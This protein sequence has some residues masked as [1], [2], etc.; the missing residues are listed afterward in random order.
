MS[1]RASAYSKSANQTTRDV[2]NLANLSETASTSRVLNLSLIH[3]AS[4]RDPDYSAAP[5]FKN[6]LLNKSLLIKHTLRPS[7][8]ELFTRPRRTATKIILPF[9]AGDL[10]LGGRSIFVNQQGYESFPR[11]YFGGT[12]RAANT[13]LLVLQHLD[14]IPSLDP[15]LVR[16]HLARFGFRPAAC[17][18]KISPHDVQQMTGFANEEIQRL[19]MTAFGAG[20]EAA[21]MKLTSKILA[22]TLDGDLDPLRETFR[23]TREDFSEGMFSWRG[24]LYFKWRQAALQEEIR[25]VLQALSSYRPLGVSDEDTRAYLNEARP[26]LA[27]KILAAVQ[28]TRKTL[29]VYDD[30][31]KALTSSA[32]PGPFRKFLIEGPGMFF[33]LGEN[34]GTLGHIGSFWTYRMGPRMKHIRL[35]PLDFADILVDFEDSLLP[36]AMSEDDEPASVSANDRVLLAF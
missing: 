3:A 8:R 25:Q 27:R 26:R 19:V 36:L 30:A 20:M 2:R 23:M 10:R 4:A 5:F 32:N 14:E 16:E 29:K 35:S 12:D 11:A 33:E 9:D 15:F 17:Y 13:D 34:I 1:S 18:L 22:N 28:A 7:E 24:F 21:A 31:Y 6:S